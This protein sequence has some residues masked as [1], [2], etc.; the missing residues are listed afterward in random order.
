MYSIIKNALGDALTEQYADV[1]MNA[2]DEN[3]SFS[4][5]FEKKMKKLIRKIDTPYYKYIGYLS[6]AA[7]AVIVIGCS[8]LLPN[9][10]SSDV[11]VATTPTETE[12]I[13][14]TD[15][16]TEA[17]PTESETSF[18]TTPP[19]SESEIVTEPSSS[20]TTAV[21]EITSESA[22][23]TEEP[24]ES[25]ADIVET[26]TTTVS[27]TTTETEY[28]Y[29]DENPGMGGRVDVTEDDDE[30]VADDDDFDYGDDDDDVGVDSDNDDD[31][32]DVDVDSDEDDDDDDIGDDSV[33][34][35][36]DEDED[37]ADDDD[38]CEDDDDVYIPSIPTEKT[39]GEE[40]NTLIGVSLVDSYPYSA[41]LYNNGVRCSR[42]D[43][44]K[45]SDIMEKARDKEIAGA[46]ENA[47][48]ID[49]TPELSERY[50]YVCISD[51]DPNLWEF[52]FNH[53]VPNVDASPR[54]DYEHNFLGKAEEIEEDAVDEEDEDVEYAIC[55]V[56]IYD[57]GVVEIKSDWS[58]AGSY[59]G[60]A[61][62]QADMG[63]VN[64]IFERLEQTEPTKTAKNVGDVLSDI[65]DSAD[66]LREVSLT[67]V[68]TVYDIRMCAPC[69]NGEYLYE[70]LKNHASNA[71][72]L[73]DTFD[74]DAMFKFTFTSAK[75]SH[76]FDLLFYADST[77]LIKTDCVGYRFEFAVD[78]AIDVLDYLC[79]LNG[80][81]PVYRYATLADYLEGKNFS[82]FT[83]LYA[84]VET[85][86]T[87]GYKVMSL[88][89]ENTEAMEK[90]NE[91][92]IYTSK[93]AYYV[94]APVNTGN[95]R[96]DASVENWNV[97]VWIGENYIS[98]GVNTFRLP[99]GTTEKILMKMEKYGVVLEKA[100]DVSVDEEW[101]D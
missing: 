69:E 39:L 89:D 100:E 35:D 37:L 76:C 19:V 4:E 21:P 87:S 98:I 12:E 28:P 96:I 26:T 14:V 56:T 53:H 79:E 52:N 62:Y 22:A 15:I 10:T 9:L 41:V 65:A 45:E 97:T 57:N 71:V 6:A 61:Y 13:I 70:L 46:L 3:Y 24:H 54:N 86:G 50:V 94:L 34:V 63:T 43:S 90:I 38:C 92:I 36:E 93:L 88:S 30:D 64:T 16:V 101:D 33:D 91:M 66:D 11:P 60:A 51:I 40:I 25:E 20:E 49:G 58:V 67:T 18:T 78:K 75:T 72:T 32:D 2:T 5:P 1:L 99:S 7:C 31:D 47:E 73:D 8:I 59:G 55:R 81:E 85:E 27:S 95:D 17:P 44:L 48:L 84:K 74:N 23:T 42:A 68:R 80:K 82:G 29:H 83:Y 77:A